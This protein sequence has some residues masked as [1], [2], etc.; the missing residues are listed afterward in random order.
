MLVARVALAEIHF[1]RGKIPSYAAAR[2]IYVYK[3]V[4]AFGVNVCLHNVNYSHGFLS[5]GSA[6]LCYAAD[7]P[8]LI[9]VLKNLTQHP[10]RPGNRLRVMVNSGPNVI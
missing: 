4:E 7:V 5:V 1:A 9:G 2:C 10:K 8:P 3:A 6:E